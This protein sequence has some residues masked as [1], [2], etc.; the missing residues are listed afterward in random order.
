MSAQLLAPRSLSRKV[1]KK[2]HGDYMTCKAFNS[3]V[4]CQWLLDCAT[5]ADEKSFP[6]SPDR[7]FGQWLEPEV[8]CGNRVFPSDERFIHLKLALTLGQEC[9]TF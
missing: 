6:A 5:H 9:N 1:I 2:V 7:I 3:R 8:A 4:I